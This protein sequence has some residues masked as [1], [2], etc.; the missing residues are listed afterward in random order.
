MKKFIYLLLLLPVLAIAQSQDQNYVKTIIYRDTTNTLPPHESVT[1][2]DG[3]GRPIQQVAGK[4]NASGMDIITHIEYD[5]YGRQVKKYLPYP[6]DRATLEF[7]GAARTNTVNYYVTKFNDSIA[8]SQSFLEPSPLGRVLKQSAPG[9]PWKGN[10][11]DDN[12]KTIKLSHQVNGTNEVK[13]FKAH[14]EWFQSRSIYNISF[15]A[16]GLD[17]YTAGQLYKTVTKDENWTSGTNHT[18][19]EFKNKDGQVVLKRTYIDGIKADTYYVYDEFGNLTYVLPPKAQGEITYLEDLCYQYKYDKRNR[20]VEKKLPGKQWEFIV[21]DSQDRVMLT[22]PTLIPFG[23]STA[24]SAE[25]GWLRTYYDAFGRVAFTGWY[26]FT[27]NAITRSTLQN[28]NNG[29]P[30][31]AVRGSGTINNIPVNYTPPTGLST[32]F[33]LLTVNYYDDYLWLPTAERPT[34]STQVEGAQVSLNTK[35]LLT[36]SWVR[37]L[38]GASSTA[39]ET[40]YTY[41]DYRG[42]ALR[43][44]ATNYLGGY[45]QVDSKLDFTGKVQYTKT[46]FKK[47]STDTALTITESFEYSDQDRLLGHTHQINS[48]DGQKLSTNT[49]NELGQLVSKNV[50]GALVLGNS[51]GTYQKVDYKYNIRGWLTDINDVEDLEAETLYPEDLFAYR[52]SYNTINGNLNNRVK[53]LY[54]GNISETQW[55]SSQDN[56]LR[57]Y[58]YAYDSANRLRDAIYQKPNDNVPVTESYNESLQYDSNGNITRIYRNGGVDDPNTIVQIDALELTYPTGSNQLTKVVDNSGSPQGFND[59]ASS[60]NGTEYTYDGNGNMLT[61]LNKGITSIKYNHLNL[62]VEIIFNNNSSRKITYLYNAAGVKLKKTVVDGAN[63]VVVDYL[64]GF[65]YKNNV[66]QFFPTAE[67]YVDFTAVGTG[68]S[69]NYVYQ[70]KDHLGNVRMNYAYTPPLKSD[71]GGLKIKEESHYYPFGLR[72]LNYNMDYLEYKEIEGS[73]VLYPPLSTQGKL[74]HNYKYNGKELQDELGLNMYDY[75]ARNYDPAL[76]RWMNIDPLAS[77]YVPYSPYAY[78]MNNPVYFIDIDGMFADG[79]GDDEP[80]DAGNLK[81][82]VITAT[83]SKSSSSANISWLPT[84]DLGKAFFGEKYLENYKSFAS[85]QNNM[86][87]YKEFHK[88]D[89][90]NGNLYGSFLA[91]IIIPEI[92]IEVVVEL[93]SMALATETVAVLEATGQEA[94]VAVVEA[95]EAIVAVEEGSHVVYQGFDA[96]GKVQYVGI[97]SRDAAV[98]FAE[99]AASGTPKSAL[100]FEIIQGATSLT[101]T[102]ARVWEQNVINQHGLP[103]LLNKIN[104]IAPS[105]WVQYGVTP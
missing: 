87:F 4:M 70:Y 29:V 61:D 9:A 44:K 23:G 91:S 37:A 45:T 95:E 60:P 79:P 18:T 38:E 8:Y 88:N 24:T 33:R 40:T 99:H 102:Q 80:I 11:G 19:E 103:N 25:Q 41:Y 20:L 98:R 13:K 50:G 7:D 27:V 100:D 32:V 69:Y 15:S 3:L 26:Y 57:K 66:L 89:E 51:L 72:H 56:V 36:G 14:A 34:S 90:K 5:S 83:R 49:Y 75:G 52:I 96:A 22:G 71:P 35:G 46:Q 76:G 74:M 62:P 10:L 104:S 59:L 55:I 84:F 17:Y 28:L 92:A 39:G 86:Q 42:R 30:V 93:G 6:T 54:N 85:N 64:S 21:Y 16:T 94:I 2:Y 67:G 31:Y 43:T 82:V 58:S 65:Q 53:E 73:I 1:Y 48:L 77:R 105:K 47:G 101:K 78:T 68:G 63:T 12:D 97:T 81:E